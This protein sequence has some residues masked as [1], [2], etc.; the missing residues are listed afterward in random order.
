MKAFQF[1]LCIPLV[2]LLLSSCLRSTSLKEQDA[3]IAE[4][5]FIDW[6]LVSNQVSDQPQYRSTFLIKNKSSHSLENWGWAIYFNQGVRNVIPGTVSENVDLTHLGGDFNCISPKE[7]FQLLPGNETTILVDCYGWLIKED[8]APS[9]VYI[10]FYDETGKERSRYAI[11]NFTVFPFERSEQINRFTIDHTPNPT[12]EWQ[13]EQNERL[14]KLDE[15]MLPLII[16]R[17]SFVSLGGEY[18][19]IDSSY[20]INYEKGLESEASFFADRLQDILD[21]KV[22]INESEGMGERIINLA[23]STLKTEESY[24]LKISKDS[25]ISV[26]GNDASGVFYGIQSLLSLIPLGNYPKKLKSFSIPTCTIEDAP[27]FPYRGMHLDV[28][29]NFNKKEA[30][31]KLIDVMSFYKLN[32]LHMHL[33]DDEGWRLQITSLPE[34]TEI[35]AFRGHTLDDHEYLHPS[36]GSGPEPDSSISYGSGFYTKEDYIQ[37]LKYAN[38]RH[39]EVIPEFDM[40]GHARAAIKA[41]DAR[42][43]RFMEEGKE[44]KAK[45]FYLA[46]P[47]D[48]SVYKSAQDYN[49]NVICVCQESTYRFIEL[50]VDEVVELYSIA[51]VPLSTIHIGGDEVP[52][53]AWKKSPVC[54]EFLKNRIEITGAAGLMDYFLMRTNNILRERN[55]ILSGW[56]EITLERDVTGDYTVKQPMESKKFQVYI[57]DNFTSGNQDIGYKVANAGYP[58]VL[59]SVTNYYFELAYNKDPKEPGDY[60]GGFVDTRKAFEYVPFDVFKSIRTTPIGRAYDPDTDFKDMVRLEPKAQSNI[61]GIQGELWSE[62]IKGP[63]MLEYFYLPKMFGLVERVWAKQPSWATL[64]D[65]VLREDALNRDWNIFANTLGQRE[66][67]RLD[68]LFG[69][70]NYRLPPPGAKVKDGFLYANSQFPGLTIRYTTDGSN[71][72]IHSKEYSKPVQVDGVISLRTFN[73]TGRS[74]RISRVIEHR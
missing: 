71:P 19:T 30:V 65:A 29:R 21:A 46:D 40:P 42:Y 9:G 68:N 1:T 32:K 72:T 52:K 28:A 24:H 38:E 56:E 45:E 44:D 4:N 63:E 3:E 74:S 17:P 39:I 60:W 2:F 57:W 11:K 15:S 34:L 13:Y 54:S 59:C 55:L 16:P 36:Y 22:G 51:E 73:S 10:V 23:F 26:L 47:E 12:P 66:M 27:R 31:F 5:I 58:L 50:L 14:E 48:A 67:P 43:R 25:G 69:G 61:L 49:D 6:E 37:I 62:P 64:D 20:R 35:G 7:S 18:A 41:M 70:Y 33:T 53:G 8:Q